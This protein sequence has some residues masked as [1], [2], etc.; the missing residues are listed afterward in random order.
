M[1]I[2]YDATLQIW[3]VYVI[4]CEE[5]ESSAK[6]GLVLFVYIHKWDSIESN[7]RSCR[8]VGKLAC[9]LSSSQQVL[10]FKTML[11]AQMTW[12]CSSSSN[13]S[14]DLWYSSL[15]RLNFL[16]V[17]MYI[18]LINSRVGIKRSCF[19]F[20]SEDITRKNQGIGYI[21]YFFIYLYTRKTR[22]ACC[23][24]CP[25]SLWIFPFWTIAQYA[26]LLPIK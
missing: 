2:I 26:S 1:K 20:K 17:C 13:M 14:I 25:R 23:V 22:F 16:C 15:K 5:K 3:G 18:I 10:L 8:L 24:V 4:V 9:P 7:I 19:L 11:T 6:K 21:R 12:A